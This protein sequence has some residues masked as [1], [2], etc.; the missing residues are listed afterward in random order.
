MNSFFN[1][2]KQL[3]HFFAGVLTSYTS[4]Y[5]ITLSILMFI[6]FIVYELDEDWHIRDQA[7]RDILFYGV[8][9]YI[10]ALMHTLIKP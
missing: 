2:L 7:Y 8:G 1:I 4:F 10:Y 3:I 5:N 9:L 6:V